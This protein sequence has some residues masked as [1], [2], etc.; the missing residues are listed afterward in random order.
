LRIQCDELTGNEQAVLL[1]LMAENRAVPNPELAQLGPKLEPGS[2][3]KFE[4]GGLIEVTP[5]RPMKIELLSDGWKLC[6]EIIKA[7]EVP[8]SPSS[9]GKAL[10]TLLRS[11]NRFVTQRDL[12]LADVFGM[13][14]EE[15]AGLIGVAAAAA[16]T[17]SAVEDQV[18]SAYRRLVARPGGWVGLALLRNELAHIPRAELDIALR[19]L[20][21]TPGVTLIPEENQ[22]VITAEDRA[23]AIEIGDQ[24]KHLIAV[25]S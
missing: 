6:G 7:G 17:G 3:K 20:Y 8:R 1:V 9:Q 18:L 25:Q 12:A 22:K 16:P 2:R 10:Y 13:A 14:N 24:H 21:R 11:L 19:H 5:G 4:D 23:A 15:E